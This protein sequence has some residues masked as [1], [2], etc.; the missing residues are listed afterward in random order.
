MS[1]TKP[2]L[3]G[4]VG[5]PS[6]GKTLA[7]LELV[8]QLKLRGY[9]ARYLEE[10]ATEYIEQTGPPIHYMEQFALA[11]GQEEMEQ[12]VL[13]PQTGKMRDFIVTGG[14][15]FAAAA[16]L[17]FYPPALDNEATVRKYHYALK[18]LDDRARTRLIPSYGAIFFTV[19][20]HGFRSDSVR[21]QGSEAD[22]LKIERKLRAYLDE[23]RVPY[24]EL[25]GSLEERMDTALKVLFAKQN[26]DAPQ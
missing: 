13:L 22:A 23:N 10:Y 2:E 15:S 17:R 25:S 20:E 14:T 24:R 7:A 6:S 16:Y 8:A 5:G 21:W 4:F 1:D 9:D 18:K 19:L 3:V 11:D 26:K 12:R